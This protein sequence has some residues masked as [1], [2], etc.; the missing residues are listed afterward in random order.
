M[1]FIDTLNRF[2]FVFLF[3]NYH[4]IGTDWEPYYGY[5]AIGCTDWW[6]SEYLDKK[7]FLDYSTSNP[8]KKRGTWRSSW[9]LDGY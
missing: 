7:V 3:P 2:E 1:R 9:R 6:L 8:F 4:E 5:E